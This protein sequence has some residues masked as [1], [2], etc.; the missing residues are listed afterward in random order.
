MFG[1]SGGI[2][3]IPTKNK[4]LKPW[5]VRFRRKKAENLTPRW[6]ACYAFQSFFKNLNETRNLLNPRTFKESNQTLNLKNHLNV[7]KHEYL[8]TKLIEHKLE[9]KSFLSKIKSKL[10]K[11]FLG[12]IQNLQRLQSFLLEL[13]TVFTNFKTKIERIIFY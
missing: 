13:I 9:S 3:T 7:K 11:L 6:H 10:V 8:K 5:I 1:V 2:G 12:T 4:Q